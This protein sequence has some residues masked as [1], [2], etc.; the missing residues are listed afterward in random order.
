[1]G[2]LYRSRRAR[3]QRLQ[4][5]GGQ[6]GG[7][8]AGRENV[9]GIVGAGVAAELAAR[10]VGDRARHTAALQG[11]LWVGL[12]ARIPFLRLNGPAPGPARLSTS[13]NICVEFAEGEALALRCDLN[14]IAIAAGAACLGGGV[15]IPPV[16]QAI[17]L[18]AT[19]ARSA[20]LLSL[21]AENTAAEVDRFLE[22]FAD[23]VVA[24]LRA[25][26]PRWEDFQRGRIRSSLAGG[27]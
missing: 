1:M 24:P 25:M 20:I 22:V 12:R 23:K 2:V 5:G 9:P 4:Q 14:G 27:G 18:D 21:G 19:L 6:E 11:R 13:L 10:E 3:L 17:G 8:R 16:L 26:S 15:R 7:L